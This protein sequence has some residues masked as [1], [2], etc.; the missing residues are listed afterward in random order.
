MVERAGFELL[1]NLLVSDSGASAVVASFE[2]VDDVIMHV[3][4]VAECLERVLYFG[5]AL[6][7]ELRMGLPY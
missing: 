3:G 2:G 4:P 5:G 1:E 6:V 7:Q